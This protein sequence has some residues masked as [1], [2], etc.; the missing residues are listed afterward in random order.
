MSYTSKALQAMRANGE[1]R[2]DWKKVDEITNDLIDDSDIPEG[3]WEDAILI[4]P[5][6]KKPI[7]FRMEEDL[8][9]WYREQAQEKHLRGYQSLMHTVLLSYK[10][11][12]ERHD[13]TKDNK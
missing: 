3:F 4:Q 9:N 8:L 7:S 12:H 10:H 2:T 5:S 1:D 13:V 11:E 6:P